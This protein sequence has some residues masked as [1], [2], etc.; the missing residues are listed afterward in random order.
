MLTLLMLLACKD[1]APADDSDSPVDTGE[2]PDPLPRREGELSLAEADAR[3]DGAAGDGMGTTA[4]G[5]GESWLLAVGIPQRNDGVGGAVLLTEPPYGDIGP[6]DELPRVPGGTLQ[7]YAGSTLAALGDSLAVGAFWDGNG[8]NLA[9]AVYLWDEPLAAGAPDGVW[10]GASGDNAGISLRTLPDWTGDGV[11][12]LLVGA[13]GADGVEGEAGRVSV[14]DGSLRGERLLSDAAVSISGREYGG[15]L[16]I[17]VSA[18]DL[19]GDGVADLLIGA[20]ADTGDASASGAAYVFYGPLTGALDTRDAD[21]S[22]AGEESYGQAGKSVSCSGDLDGDGLAD[23]AIGAPE[24]GDGGF[25]FVHNAAP[26]GVVAVREG[27]LA[28]FSAESPGDRAGFSV[29]IVGDR[30]L[31][32]QDEL[33]IGAPR[34]AA[35]GERAGAAYLLYGPPEGLVAAADA[36]WI[37]RGEAAEARAGSFVGAGPDFNQDHAPELMVGSYALNDGAGALY[38][39]Y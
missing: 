24:G 23:L 29:A 4:V 12:E 1:P 22:F 25:V 11:D 5:S 38:L 19:D 17:S 34:N 39:L 10:I 16:G 26:L 15:Y 28:V 37:L 2:R 32:G 3:I 35:A 30:D 18:N 6:D 13:I 7:S 14:L 31:D 36:A 27:A 21:G 20:L 9:G 33:M 8:G